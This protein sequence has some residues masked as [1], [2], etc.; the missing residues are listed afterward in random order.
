MKWSLVL[1]AIVWLA[2]PVAAGQEGQAPSGVGSLRLLAAKP[3]E[4]PAAPAVPPIVAAG[5]SGP[6]SMSPV[7][8]VDLV[9]RVCRPAV[10]G[11]GGDV[12]ALAVSLGLGDA[13]PPPAEMAR[14]LPNGA[15]LWRVPSLDG[16]LYLVMHGEARNCSAAVLRPMPEAGFDQA[17]RLLQAPE[18][19]FMP[20]SSQT[21]A[22]D[23]R[24][25]RLRSPKG[26]FVDL[27]EYPPSGEETPGVLRV[28]YLPQ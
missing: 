16:E 17:S 8:V 24:W 4:T 26:E 22:G 18:Q 23:V 27:M 25:S 11:D 9:S 3:A 14:A 6:V 15:A 13:K 19:G 12:Q 10:T 2:A 7:A 1:T 28:D 21:L 20:D 5:W